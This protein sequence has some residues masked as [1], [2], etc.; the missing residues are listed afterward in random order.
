ML[1]ER[2]ETPLAARGGS[3]GKLYLARRVTLPVDEHHPRVVFGDESD[4]AQMPV[5]AVQTV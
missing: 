1:G 4:V 3:L 2:R 5:M